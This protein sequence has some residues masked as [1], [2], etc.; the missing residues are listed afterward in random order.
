M[1]LALA[2]SLPVLFAALLA[3]ACASTPVEQRVRFE[4]VERFE[5]PGNELTIERVDSVGEPLGRG[6]TL[7]VRGSYRLESHDS[8]LLYFGLTDGVAEGAETRAVQRGPGRFDLEVR[9]MRPGRPHVTLYAGPGPDQ[10]IGK[11][12][13][14]L[15]AA[16]HGED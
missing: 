6:T 4:V 8:A 11:R 1:R 9:V 13:I 2:A 14:E 7:R 16:H 5:A 12:R 15:L 3:A 10:V